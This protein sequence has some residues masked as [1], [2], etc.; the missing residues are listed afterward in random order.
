MAEKNI[1]PI[2]AELRH[3]VDEPLRCPEVEPL[4]GEVPQRS[5]HYL[6]V[7]RAELELQSAQFG[8]SR[9]YLET[10]QLVKGELQRQGVRADSAEEERL[11]LEHLLF[12]TQKLECMGVL[13]SGIAHDLNNIL[14]IIVGNVDLAMLRIDRESPAAENL[15]RIEQASARAAGLIKQMLAYSGK[16]K[17]SVENLDLNL[18]L[19]ELLPLLGVSISK[20][21]AFRLNLHPSLPPVEADATQI[22]QIVMNLVIN[23][24]EA[25]GDNAGVIGITTDLIDCDRTYLMDTGLDGDVGEGPCVCLEVADTGCGMDQETVE[26]LFDPFFTTKFTGRGL[27]MAAVL[28]IVKG[29]RG[30]VK[31]M[32]EPGKGTTF[33]ILL[34]VSGHPAGPSCRSVHPDDWKGSGAVLLVDDEETVRGVG[35]EMLRELGFTPIT[36]KDGVEAIGIFSK[37][38][39]IALVILDLTMPRLSGEQCFRELRKLDPRVKVIMSSGYDEQ[40]VAPKFIGKGLSGFIQKPYNLALLRDTIRCANCEVAH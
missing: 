30:S 23:A 21:A 29:H 31:V 2:S 10:A 1:Y 32:S 16:G 33:R 11:R 37:T 15:H 26:K 3:F 20:K 8:K 14:M 7:H 9:D 35:S 28:G 38:P 25:I 13:A 4:A 27:G 19:E 24:S 12:H 39:G 40:E 18:L 17:F 5:Q 36:A 34:P 22:Q 6:K